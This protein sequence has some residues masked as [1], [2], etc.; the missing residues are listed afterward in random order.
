[1]NAIELYREFPETETREQQALM[2]VW[3]VGQLLKI[4]A[5]RFFREYLSSEMQ[6]NIML[7]LKHADHPMN[8]QELSEKLLV[9]KSNLTGVAGRMEAAGL[10]IR[11]VDPL[12][13]RAYQL[14]LTSRGRKILEHVEMPYRAEVKKV[15]ADFS[16]AELSMLIRFMERMRKTL[17]SEE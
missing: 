1:M 15:M 4:Q 12:D 2:G 10:L 8:Q 3:H 11:R 9:D 13:S 17:N 5:R 14:E 16:P 7:L 6:F